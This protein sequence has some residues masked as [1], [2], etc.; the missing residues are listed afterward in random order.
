MN[1][2]DDYYEDEDDECIINKSENISCFTIKKR[3]SDNDIS[4]FIKKTEKKKEDSTQNAEKKMKESKGK[5]KIIS[6]LNQNKKK[7]T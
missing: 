3:G 5:E 7:K 2:D 4:K 6:N 1:F